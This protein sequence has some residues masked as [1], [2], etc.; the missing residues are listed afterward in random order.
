MAIEWTAEEQTFAKT[1]QK[2][3]KLPEKGLT[4][5]VLPII[6]ERTTGGGSDCGDVCFN[7]PLSIFGWPTV[8]LGVAMHTWGVTA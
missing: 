4:T 1:I 8:P 2:E 3:M 7:T 5:A 6:G